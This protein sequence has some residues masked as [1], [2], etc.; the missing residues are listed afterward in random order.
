M[1]TIYCVK[2]KQELEGLSRVPYP[3]AL[4]QRIY[5]S[6]SKQAWQ[7]WLVHQTLLINENRLNLLDESTR[8]FLEEEMQ[9]FLF[10]DDAEKPTGYRPISNDNPDR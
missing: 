6:I 3:G 9:K 4:G 5:E 2:L 7:A 1:R 10:S 8:R